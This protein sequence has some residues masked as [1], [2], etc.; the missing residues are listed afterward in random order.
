[1]NNSNI[2]TGSNDTFLLSF[3]RPATVGFVRR[4]LAGRLPDLFSQIECGLNEREISNFA[5]KRGWNLATG[6]IEQPGDNKVFFEK[7]EPG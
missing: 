1:M 3:L 2:I 4:E 5:G 7:T 6:W